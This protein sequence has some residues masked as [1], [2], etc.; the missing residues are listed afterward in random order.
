V[1]S[2]TALAKGWWP[3]GVGVPSSKDSVTHTHL[4]IIEA[5]LTSTSRKYQIFSLQHVQSLQH[6]KSQQH[7]K[8]TLASQPFL[9]QSS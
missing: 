6:P 3:S 4:G 1:E 8:S 7:D 2:S 9:A 5:M